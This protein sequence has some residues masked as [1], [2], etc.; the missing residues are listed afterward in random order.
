M[1]EHSETPTPT[2]KKVRH[3][4]T[5]VHKP[6]HDSHQPHMLTHLH[7]LSSDKLHDSKSIVNHTKDDVHDSSVHTKN[8]SRIHENDEIFNEHFEH[9]HHPSASPHTN[10]NVPVVH[11]DKYTCTPMHVHT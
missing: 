11:N 8:I 4:T 9:Q 10:I 6:Y 5:S 3:K 2:P 1:L 7:E